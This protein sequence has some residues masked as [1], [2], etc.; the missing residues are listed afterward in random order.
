M[1]DFPKDSYSD[2]VES[3]TAPSEL[4]NLPR[5][6]KTFN[7]THKLKVELLP[8]IGEPNATFANA[9]GLFARFEGYNNSGNANPYIYNDATTFYATLEP[10]KEVLYLFAKA[11]QETPTT[12]VDINLLSITPINFV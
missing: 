5:F 10:V 7:Y 1:F 4:Q 9:T 8:N 3:Y 12:E 11:N 6:S 2:V